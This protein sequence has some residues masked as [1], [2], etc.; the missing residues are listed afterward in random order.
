MDEITSENLA[1]TCAPRY[2]CIRGRP[3]VFVPVVTQLV[4]QP[5]AA[6]PAIRNSRAPPDADALCSRIHW[7]ASALA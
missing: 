5:C 3:P 7:R 4:T 2:V 6:C 1:L